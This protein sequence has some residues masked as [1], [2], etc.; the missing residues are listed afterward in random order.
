MSARPRIVVLNDWER[1][2]SRLADWKAIEARADL[3]ILH[4]PLQGDALVHA[5]KD[6]DA[7]VL[8]RD[9]SP[10]DAALIAQ[11][12]KLRY[13]VFTG[14]RNTTLDLKALQTRGIPVS[15]TEWG[16]SKDSTCE[17]TW[18][19]ILAAMRQLPAQTA[20]LREGRWRAPEGGP[21]P[22]VLRGARLGLIGLGE[23]GGR[24]ARIGQA[25]GMDVAAW[26][27]HMTQERADA[28]GATSVP[29]E[30]LLA[31]SQVVSL[32]LVPTAATRHLL[33]AERLASMQPGSLLVNT[34]RSAL[35]DPAA[36]AQALRNGR[37]GMAALDVFDSEPLPADEPLRKVPNLL[38][39]PHT[40]FV[41]E[42]VFQQFAL[43]VVECLEAWLDGRIVR[44]A[45]TPAA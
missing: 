29:L 26:S 37:P 34:S 36:L 4:E 19:L 12:P 1:A 38:M 42:P 45:A 28:Y 33:N 39:T 6:A 18:A 22:G 9:R 24:V 30:T 21:L 35:I 7:V 15:H 10:F 27:P 13:L 41:C 43:G 25:F 2:L 14:T 5:L 32:H 3:Q 31:T 23:I 17:M 40:G 8:V 16:P 20:L 11:L 44:P